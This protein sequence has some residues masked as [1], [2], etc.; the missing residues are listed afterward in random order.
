MILIDSTDE[1][2]SFK[3]R[4]EMLIETAEELLPRLVRS[5]RAKT[6]IENHAINVAVDNRSGVF[7][8]HLTPTCC[9]PS[10]NGN[11]S[12]KSLVEA[13]IDEL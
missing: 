7:L 1:R 10:R 2:T 12:T 5:H 8:R 3:P 9:K 13:R 11:R 6:V 4:V